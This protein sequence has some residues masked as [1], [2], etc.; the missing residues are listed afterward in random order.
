MPTRNACVFISNGEGICPDGRS[1]GGAFMSDE[2]DTMVECVEEFERM[3]KIRDCRVII[4]VV[5]GACSDR[6][7][8]GASRIRTIFWEG[9]AEGWEEAVVVR[10]LMA[11]SITDR[12]CDRSV[13]LSLNILEGIGCGACAGM[14]FDT[15]APSVGP[16]TLDEPGACL[17]GMGL[18]PGIAVLEGGD[19]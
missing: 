10:E 5:V 6:R 7:T 8:S 15:C 14:A 12:V 2:R 18:R 13:D 9:G 16:W 4:G 3:A 1:E 19:S 11:S 17:R